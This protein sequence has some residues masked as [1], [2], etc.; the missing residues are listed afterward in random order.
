[1][2]WV[3]AA[4]GWRIGRTWGLIVAGLL[5]FSVSDCLYLFQTAAGSYVAGGATDL[6]WVGGCVLL[7]WAA[8]Q[9]AGQTIRARLEGWAVLIA[10]IGCGLLALAVLVYDHF[11]PVNPLSLVLSTAAILAVLAR[12]AMTFGENMQDA[13][14]LPQRGS[15]RCPRGPRNRRMPLDDLAATLRRE[16]GACPRRVRPERLQAP[17]TIPSAIP[18]AM[19]LLPRLGEKLDR[20]VVGRGSACVMGGD[21]FCILGAWRT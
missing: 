11:R 2:V 15:H 1:M 16:D 21:E 9:P 20:S 4:P 8:W 5:V 18:P 14:R 13:R 6:G 7:A 12:L 10:P 19:P 3:L 17:P